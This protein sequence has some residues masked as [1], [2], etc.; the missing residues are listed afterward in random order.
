MLAAEAVPT[1][2]HQADA[3]ANSHATTGIYEQVSSTELTYN[4]RSMD[5]F[6]PE[7]TAHYISQVCATAVSFRVLR[8]RILLG[9]NFG[10][11]LQ[12]AVAGSHRCSHGVTG[13]VGGQRAEGLQVW[14]DTHTSSCCVSPTSTAD[15][16]V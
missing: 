6:V 2:Q 10:E 11:S 12:Q 14:C 5:T 13:L 7:R 3:F 15:R 8:P 16:Y 4:G 9:S 1:H